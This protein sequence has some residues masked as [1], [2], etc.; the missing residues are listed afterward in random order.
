MNTT[1]DKD[2]ETKNLDLALLPRAFPAS[3]LVAGLML[4]CAY[5]ADLLS[6]FPPRLYD[7]QWQIAFAEGAMNS[8][9]VPV[10]GSI[11]L[12]LGFWLGDAIRGQKNKGIQR[13]VYALVLLFGIALFLLVPLYIS[14]VTKIFDAQIAKVE[15]QRDQIKPEPGSELAV[16]FNSAIDVA[17]GQYW[18]RLLR[19]SANGVFHGAALFVI[20]LAGIR[21]ARDK[22]DAGFECPSCRSGRIAPAVKTPIEASLSILRIHPFTCQECSFRFRRFSLTGRPYRF[23]F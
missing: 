14:N 18:R 1:S 7:L 17:Q 19:M 10:I 12:L 23:F 13:F 22:A 6:Q 11:F 5:T 2:L 8:A 16:R 4:I 3:I 15:Q 20:A 9:T 21:Y